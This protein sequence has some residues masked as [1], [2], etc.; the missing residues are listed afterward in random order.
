MSAQSPPKGTLRIHDRVSSLVEGHL[1]LV[2]KGTPPLVRSYLS[3]EV[4]GDGDWQARLESS[5]WIL[6]FDHPI[7]RP[8]HTTHRELPLMDELGTSFQLMLY[9]ADHTPVREAHLTLHGLSPGRVRLELRGRTDMRW[10]REYDRDLEIELIAELSLERVLALSAVDEL[11][12]REILAAAR[13]PSGA[14]D[15]QRQPANWGVQFGPVLTE[16]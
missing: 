13:L 7:F 5:S 3:F 8:G 9:V 4:R 14:G 16:P 10:S 2:L 11:S 15:F 1:I 6:V 12:G